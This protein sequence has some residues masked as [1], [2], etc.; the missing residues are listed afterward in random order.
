MQK[1]FTAE[2]L[3]QLGIISK[4]LAGQMKPH[5]LVLLQGPLG[6]GKTALVKQL[7]RHFGYAARRV[8]SPTFSLLNTYH[9]GRFDFFH[10]DLY[11]L[12]NHDYFLLEEMKEL[13]SG[14][15]AVL[16]V[17]WPEKIRLSELSSLADRLISV[18]IEHDGKDFRKF[19]ICVN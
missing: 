12:D 13:L 5:T 11:R 6:S 9:V 7:A 14:D 16:L 19:R 10:L 18:N 17:E 15:R 1:D 3:S 8:K 2:K 4:W